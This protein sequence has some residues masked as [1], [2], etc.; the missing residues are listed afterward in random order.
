[1]A[2]VNTEILLYESTFLF[3]FPGILYI[4]SDLQRFFTFDCNLQKKKTTI[5]IPQMQRIA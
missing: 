4:K 3:T 5:K 2:G 1:M